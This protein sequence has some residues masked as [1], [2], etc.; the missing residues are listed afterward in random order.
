MDG[1]S[2]IS[3][4]AK[5]TGKEK[6]IRIGLWILAFVFLLLSI[7][8]W[9]ALL[10]AV[11]CFAAAYFYSSNLDYEYEYIFSDRDLSVDRI[12]QKSRRK[13]KVLIPFAEIEEIRAVSKKDTQGILCCNE[14]DPKIELVCNGRQGK[15]TYLILDSE[16][17]RTS[18][19][20]A[21][22]KKAVALKYNR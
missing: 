17:V 21:M 15:R 11:I 18:L 14:D 13:T 7:L 5:P 2:E 20:Q 9:P 6:S 12:I 22:P 10:G 1:I 16:A 3:F 4:A 19:F 8:A